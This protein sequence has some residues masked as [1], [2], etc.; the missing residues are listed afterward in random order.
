MTVG[1]CF[2][3]IGVTLILC[4]ALRRFSEEQEIDLPEIEQV[5]LDDVFN[6]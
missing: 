4:G 3:I 5:P 2:M 6:L 1:L